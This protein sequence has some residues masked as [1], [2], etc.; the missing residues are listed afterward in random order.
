VVSPYQ[1][2][3]LQAGVPHARIERYPRSGHFIM[4]DE[5]QVFMETLRNF[6]DNGVPCP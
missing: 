3:P 5:P 4:L 6:L 1:W 2:R